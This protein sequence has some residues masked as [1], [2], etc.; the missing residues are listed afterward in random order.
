MGIRQE[1][2]EQLAAKFEVLFPHL[3]ERRRR[4]LMGA[5]ARLLGHGGIRTVA[6]AAGK[7]EATVRKGVDELEAGEGP[8]G[9]VRRPGGGRKSLAET[10]PGLRPAL[11]A[12]VEPDERGD[13]MSPLRW[14]TKSTRRLAAELTRQ[15][16]KV[17]A[18]TVG[19]LLRQEGFSLQA[20][21]KTI[22][23][24]QHP[25]RD[26]Q[27]RYINE[28]ARQHIDAGQPVISV[29]T[30]K[31]EL[32]GNYRNNGR[33]W[34]PS[35]E[36]V[37]VR[38]HDFLDQPGSGRA[39]PYGIYDVAANT[40][41]VSVGT[42][43]DT[44]AFAVASI[45][46]WWHGRGR[47]DYPQ[48]ARL[49]I[50]ADAGGSNGF[51]TRTW[52]TELAALAAETGLEITVCHLPPGASKW[53]KIEHRLF[54]HITMNWRGKPLTSHEVILNSIAATTTATGLTVHA[55]LDTGTYPTGITVTDT[56]IDALAM[57]RHRF[58]GDW[59]Y[60]LHPTAQDPAANG[61]N[62]TADTP[63]K[64]PARSLQDPELTGM[65]HRQL[66]DLTTAL[67]PELECHREQSRAT[68]RGGR[69]SQ[70]PG[71]GPKDKL[72]H[73]DRILATVLY[74]R[75]LAPQHLLGQLFGVTTMTISRTVREVRP[76]LEA[77]GY[78][79]TASTARF[80]T[81]ADVTAFLT[82]GTAS[83]HPKSAC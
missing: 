60:T 49:L 70:V 65:T 4:L 32:V 54:S 29:D 23:G 27:F 3:D 14:T 9:R 11:L 62:E 24:K 63:W 38:T 12:L 46:R 50:T 2:R 15:G 42:D 37:K 26:A 69:P 28:R 31:K 75:K 18:D 36:P 44:A 47:H 55:E 7:S 53:N 6:R 20:N 64:L 25:D 30:K 13:P 51:R 40:G 61:A 77:R 78:R 19:D 80:H 33:E 71:A 41:W 81:P 45:R 83:D 43:H 57:H 73:A 48:A 22:E 35:G 1:T 17:G 39:I 21:A 10:D 79:I 8:L 5:E 52:K 34:R 72:T 56:Q 74:L 82:P 68:R 16:H 59:N 66:D 76:L 67:T 58:H